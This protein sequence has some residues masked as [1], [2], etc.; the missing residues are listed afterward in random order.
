MPPI[1]QAVR[2]ITISNVCQKLKDNANQ[3]ITV[4]DRPTVIT[5]HRY[6]YVAIENKQARLANSGMPWLA[7]R[8]NCLEEV[9]AASGPPRL[10]S[11]IGGQVQ[12]KG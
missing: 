6:Q 4:R 11:P 2:L 8:V 5:W 10:V 7:L 9:Q 12:W 1:K 3:I